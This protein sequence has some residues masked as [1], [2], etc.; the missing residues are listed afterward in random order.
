M[1]SGA[2]LSSYSAHINKTAHLIRKENSHYDMKLN[3]ESK[4]VQPKITNI[5]AKSG[6]IKK[7][8]EQISGNENADSKLL[9]E[10]NKDK[11]KIKNKSKNE[12]EKNLKDDIR[13]S[14]PVNTLKKNN[15]IDL[16]N[17]PKIF[18]HFLNNNKNTESINTNL[19][20]RTTDQ[21]KVME[22]QETKNE[23]MQIISN[24]NGPVRQPKS[25]HSASASLHMDHLCNFSKRKH[26][27]DKRESNMSN[28]L[29]LLNYMNFKREEEKKE[30]FIRNKYKILLEDY[31]IRNEY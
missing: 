29:S 31:L 1:V 15:K 3:K 20:N 21:P 14:S 22:T 30:V 12:S 17:A 8:K 7:V 16:S 19:V 18:S 13:D 28:E 25:V 2:S 4:Q 24:M 11:N 9:K 6:I 23:L 5:K 26:T 27:E 10:R